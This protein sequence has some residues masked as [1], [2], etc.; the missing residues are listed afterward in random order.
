[1][2]PSDSPIHTATMSPTPID[3]AYSGKEQTYYST[4]TL[5][6]ALKKRE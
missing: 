1:M 6:R 5:R 3:P 2:D 4:S